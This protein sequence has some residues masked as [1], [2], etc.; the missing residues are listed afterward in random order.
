MKSVVQKVWLLFALV[1][2][3]F[4]PSRLR[5][6]IDV[7]HL[8]G[9]GNPANGALSYQAAYTAFGEHN[10][11]VPTSLVLPGSPPNTMAVQ[12]YGAE[13]WT[14]TGAL[15]DHFRK[16]TKE[17]SDSGLINEGQRYFDPEMG[18]FLT[19]DPLGLAD[20][21]NP[22]TYVHQNP[23]TNFDPEGLEHE[24]AAGTAVGILDTLFQNLK[25]FAGMAGNPLVDGVYGVYGTGLKSIED[26][27]VKSVGANP[28]DARFVNA[29]DYAKL[30][31]Q[32]VVDLGSLGAG[33]EIKGE[34]GVVKLAEKAE[35][36]IGVGAKLTEE[37]KVAAGA[38]P[39][40]SA[41]TDE[42]SS[43]IRTSAN[44]GIN[45]AGGSVESQLTDAAGR[46]VETIGPG[47]GAVYGT[48]VHAAFEAEVKEL[49]GDFSTEV[50]YLDG[51]KVDRGTPGSVRL[52]VVQ[53]PIKAPTAIFDLKTG[54]AELTPAR[55]KQIQKHVPGGANVPIKAIKPP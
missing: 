27:T 30:G 20:G 36:E 50:S 41:A 26:K 11:N 12:G 51:V 15:T 13:E 31:T 37:A 5:A 6:S 14:A 3:C 47:K 1:A 44:G 7:L 29:R 53:G 23:W 19:A 52:D 9:V 38:A 45:S 25:S 55:I 21:T 10:P 43:E 49:F 35:Q 16:N 2:A 40:T 17:E 22:Y 42:I 39:S 48:K 28:H 34:Q 46:A 18:R 8:P 54:S 32:A 4:A 33:P 24:A